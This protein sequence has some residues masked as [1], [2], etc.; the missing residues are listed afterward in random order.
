[1]FSSKKKLP[2]CHY[3]TAF[4]WFFSQK[5]FVISSTLFFFSFFFSF[6]LT[7]FGMIKKTLSYHMKLQHSFLGKFL[8]QNIILLFRN[9]FSLSFFF[10]LLL[11]IFRCNLN[12]PISD[13]PINLRAQSLDRSSFGHRS[14][15]RNI[16]SRKGKWN[17]GCIA[18]SAFFRS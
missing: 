12:F 5:E 16:R 2:S 4:S 8:L 7:C 18:K 14:D 13:G 15:H 1:M 3:L 10:I 9:F 11:F 17:R 6:R